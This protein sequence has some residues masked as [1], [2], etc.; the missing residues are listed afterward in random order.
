[1]KFVIVRLSSLGDIVH[2]L[3]VVYF[4]R[5]HFPEAQIDW[6]TGKKG[7]EFLLQIS[8]INNVYLASLKNILLIQKQNYDY[9]I[10]VQGLFK[11]GFLSRLCNGK[12]VIGFKDT[13]EFAD[14]FYDVKTNVGNLFKTN[15][16]IVDLNLEL[17]KSIV[18]EDFKNAKFLI[19]K[20]IRVE[21][22][23][24]K[25]ITKKSMV[26]F[27]AT[28][29]KSKLWGMG[30]W[31][32]VIKKLQN[33]YQIFLCA[34]NV[35]K[36]CIKDLVNKL[37][38]E[39][40]NYNNLAGETSIKDLIYLIQNVTLVVGLDSA[41]LHLASAIRN[42][43]GTPEVIGIYGP[44]SLYRC[45]PYGTLDSCLYLKD[46][47]CIACRKKVCPLGHHACM[48]EIS[49]MHVLNKIEQVVESPNMINL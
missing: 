22:P 42:D 47:D 8:E 31:F 35:D 30:S 23:A 41:G 39:N 3:P 40:V 9:V 21:N 37:D 1:M 36:E 44:T 10:D 5:K 26:I 33:N 24:L 25:N 29:W 32:E 19:P 27:P 14:I 20:L 46:L 43:F 48:S 18:K 2:S 12:K 11:T 34:S 4:L 38:S 6:L 28:T 45:G 13:R 7:Y 16:H 49:P 17:L 15:K